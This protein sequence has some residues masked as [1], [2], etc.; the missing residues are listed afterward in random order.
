M[1]DWKWTNRAY[2][3]ATLLAAMGIGYSNPLYAQ[4][5]QLT[6]HPLL[7]P[8][9]GMVGVELKN[10][11]V[12]FIPPVAGENAENA[13]QRPPP[14]S[15]QK[16]R[17]GGGGGGGPGDFGAAGAV[18]V[19]TA[20]P[21][22]STSPIDD[23]ATCAAGSYQ[24]EPMLAANTGLASLGGSQND[25]YPGACKASATPGTFGDCGPSA[26]IYPVS[27]NSWQRYKL[28]RSWGAHNFLLGYD[29]SVAVDSA[30][31]YFIAY[32]VSDGSPSGANGLV[33]VG[34][35]DGSSWTKTKAIVLNLSGGNF[36][37]KPWIAADAGATS[38]Y[39]DRLY[40]AWDRN[41]GNNQILLVS[42]S[43]DHGQS[44]STPQK[45]NDGTTSFERVIYAFPAVVPDG[46][47]AVYVLW[48]DYAR[49]KIFIDKS[50]NGG[51]TWGTDMVVASTNTGFAVD[52]GCNGTRSMTPAPQMAINADG[53]I[54][55]TFAKNVASSGVQLAVFIT[56]SPDG[57]AHW[58]TPQR[59]STT[60]S[61]QYNPAV[62]LDGSGHV[63]VSYLDRR[64]DLSNCSTNTYLSS[65][66]LPTPSIGTDGSV[67]AAFNFADTL[68]SSA[69][70][71]FDGNPNGPGDY[72]GI[73]TLQSAT[74]SVFPYFS[75]HRSGDFEI[76]A[77]RLSQ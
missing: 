65:A 10:G 14:S 70:S 57:G 38:P 35:A 42:Y 2:A 76:F 43:T 39:K 52:I 51:V 67:T 6:N 75:D 45:I 32:G 54:Y 1:I 53:R 72:Q 34:S 59:V 37:D 68:V 58:S 20:C 33:A 73:A 18:P 16:P 49:N 47:G 26:T 4:P 3:V 71:D 12:V 15:L 55:V 40:V 21:G 74:P 36:E 28:S 56:M 29:G 27:S 69:S 13:G 24:G 22:W 25:I 7:L 50:T 63:R 48:H 61:H 64:A 62:A 31:R 19:G 23:D 60:N 17:G 46:S 30:G 11:H 77:G 9:S 8:T 41:Q 44:W 5:S 66:T